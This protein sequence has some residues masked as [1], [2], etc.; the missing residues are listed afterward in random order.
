MNTSD[1]LI[2]V[3]QFYHREARRCSRIHAYLAASIMQASA[4]EA[5]LQAMCFLYPEHV[6]KT[7]SHR[8]KRFRRGRNRALEFTLNELIKIASELGWF[9]PTTITLGTK[10][11]NLT[12]LA[13]Q[14]REIRNLVHPGKWAREHSRTTKI[15][16]QLYESVFE[17]FDV[18]TSWLLHRVERSLLRHMR[19]EGV[20]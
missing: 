4:L 1:R 12:E 10:K 8:R 13:H 15:N 3:A 5:S 19:R 16:K 18:A 14:V 2:E 11:T 6:K 7:T 17:V 20:V 9:P